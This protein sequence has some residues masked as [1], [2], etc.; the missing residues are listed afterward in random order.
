MFLFTHPRARYFD[1][2]LFLLLIALTIRILIAWIEMPSLVAIVPDDA[3]YYFAIARNIIENN[4]ITFDGSNW[5][6]GFHPLWL[7]IIVPLFAVSVGDPFL[8]IHLTLSIAALLDCLTGWVIGFLVYQ[9]TRDKLSAFVASFFYVLNPG[10]IIESLNGLETALNTFVIAFV[11][12][13][14]LRCLKNGKL[15]SGTLVWLALG[16]GF[17]LAVLART[18]NVVLVAAM[19]SGLMVKDHT[20]ANWGHLFRVAMVTTLLFLPW[21]MWNQLQFGSILQSS[22]E[23]FP[24]AIRTSFYANRSFSLIDD[25]MIG[26][27]WLFK[28]ALEY[29][30]FYYFLRQ[31]EW[32]II[33]DGLFIGGLALCVLARNPH[34]RQWRSALSCLHFPALGMMFLFL[35]HA[36]VRWYP[37]SWYF[38]P[39]VFFVAIAIGITFAYVTRALTNKMTYRVSLAAVL[40]FIIGVGFLLHGIRYWERYPWQREMFLAGNWLQEN[41]AAEKAGAFNAGIVG[42]IAHNRVINLDGVINSNAYS[43]I[44]TKSLAHYIEQEK[45]KVIVDFSHSV[46]LYRLFMGQPIELEPIWSWHIAPEPAS[47]THLTIFSLSFPN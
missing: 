20:R 11:F 9:L 31:S 38:M 23:A 6:N 12:S 34:T 2:N 17:G 19:L 29:I 25:L 1:I 45:I 22:G 43:A 47:N 18:D 36:L 27:V 26:M 30:P 40:C 37:R 42:Y 4:G 44:R 21:L 7:G 28:W 39:L 5:T 46:N 3:F 32:G 41:L 24:Y 14:Y 13:I 8:P 35:I 33:Y 10:V 15:A 16:I